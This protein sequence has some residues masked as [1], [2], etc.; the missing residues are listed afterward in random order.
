MTDHLLDRPIWAALGTGQSGLAIGGPNA[1][2]Y[3]SDISPL[4]AVRDVGA[5]SLRDYAAL[6][7]P[8]ETVILAQRE[9]CPV[10]PG[11]VEEVRAD[12]AQMIATDL[13]TAEATDEV[14]SLGDADAPEMLEL[15]TL[16]KPGPFLARTHE[17]GDFIG[18]R[19][20]GR[21]IAM[22]G[23]RMHPVGYCEVSGVCTHPDFRGRGHA[24]LLTRIVATRIV[25]RGEIP[26]LHA[27]TANQAA[28]GVYEK[29]GFSRRCDLTMQ[30][31]KRG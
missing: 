26:F 25:E 27:Y 15:A 6:V 1:R 28:I 31:F 3:P 14:I 18:I 24:G 13:H 7:A 17:L 11:L 12:L 23:E 16:T 29:I 8:G 22:A 4:S 5:E 2:R 20:G 9:P 21:L 19:E 10:P 30:V